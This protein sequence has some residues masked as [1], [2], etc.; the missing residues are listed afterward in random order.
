MCTRTDPSTTTTVGWGGDGI[1]G[2]TRRDRKTHCFCFFHPVSS[3]KSLRDRC[4][5]Y[6]T[7][8]SIITCL[9]PLPPSLSLTLF[10]PIKNVISRYRPVVVVFFVYGFVSDRMGFFSFCRFKNFRWEHDAPAP[11][12]SAS[13]RSRHKI[14]INSDRRKRPYTT[15]TYETFRRLSGNGGMT[16]VRTHVF[17]NVAF[18]R[19]PGQRR[20]FFG[21]DGEKWKNRR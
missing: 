13:T 18:K 4:A 14:Y 21:R 10:F 16:R 8:R 1:A 6:V 5:I 2:D 9:F 12:S 3:P 15:G 19:S 20:V 11:H 7:I 17:G